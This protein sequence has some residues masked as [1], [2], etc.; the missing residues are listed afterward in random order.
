MAKTVFAIADI[1]SDYRSAYPKLARVENNLVP[2]W[3]ALSGLPLEGYSVFK[4]ALTDLAT[5]VEDIQAFVDKRVKEKVGVRALLMKLGWHGDRTRLERMEAALETSK[6]TL[7]ITIQAWQLVL[8]EAD[9]EELVAGLEASMQE[10]MK[11]VSGY[12]FAPKCI[13]NIR[14]HLDSVTRSL[15]ERQPKAG[16]VATVTEVDMGKPLTT[17]PTFEAWLDSF[18]LSQGDIER[19]KL[20]FDEN[21]RRLAG[22]G[23]RVDVE[24][25]VVNGTHGQKSGG[26][27]TVKVRITGLNGHKPKKGK[28]V[29]CRLQRCINAVLRKR[30]TLRAGTHQTPWATS[31]F[32]STLDNLPVWWLISSNQA[33]LTLA[34]HE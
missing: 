28:I 26:Q 9:R 30:A 17:W 19:D 29:I 5:N 3:E 1:P 32:S 27:K 20:T 7:M 31:N 24:A 11:K 8:R 10:T 21:L 4:N 2:I 25:K 6:S 34:Q 16:V 23:D 15:Q 33:C 18:T 13:Q 12:E 14:A 22:Q